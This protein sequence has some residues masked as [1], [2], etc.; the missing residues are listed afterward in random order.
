VELEIKRG[1]KREKTGVLE[2][3]KKVLVGRPGKGSRKPEIKNLK[4]MVWFLRPGSRNGIGTQ[5]VE[6]RNGP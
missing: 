6:A 1:W 4:R 2:G 5:G 3:L